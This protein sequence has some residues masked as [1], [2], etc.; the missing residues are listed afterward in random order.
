MPE[1]HFTIHQ[2]GSYGI[3]GMMTFST[4]PELLAKT[5]A[6]LCDHDGAVTI[7]LQQVRHV[8]SAGLAL[9]LE[10]MRLARE[11]GRSLQFEN[12]PEQLTKLI[13]VSNLQSLF[14]SSHS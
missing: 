8:D 2:N 9:L 13:N 7:N 6:W 5:D 1:S 14:Q 3:E 11:A 12:I 10:W 4:V